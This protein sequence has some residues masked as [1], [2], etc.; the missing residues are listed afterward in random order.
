M[1]G[2]SFP[3]LKFKLPIFVS[4]KVGAQPTHSKTKKRILS[5]LT[6]DD[7]SL[8]NEAEI[9]S[10]L[11]ISVHIFTCLLGWNIILNQKYVLEKVGLR[12]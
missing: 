9:L 1:I 3:K 5:L 10:G 8:G 2:W 11:I 6:E 12:L 4:S 7:V